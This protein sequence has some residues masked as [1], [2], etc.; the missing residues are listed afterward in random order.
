[1]CPRGSWTAWIFLRNVP[2]NWVGIS[3]PSSICC[4]TCDRVFGCCRCNQRATYSS[5]CS[6]TQPTALFMTSRQM[7]AESMQLFYGSNQFVIKGMAHKVLL[8]LS[9]IPVTHLRLV[10]RLCI[11]AKVASGKQYW[12]WRSVFVL[13]QEQLGTSACTITIVFSSIFTK[14]DGS[15]R[16]NDQLFIQRFYNILRE[17]RFEY[18][19]VLI[20]T[21]DRTYRKYLEWSE[22]RLAKGVY[23]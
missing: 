12:R 2:L 18:L 10:K 7:R 4:G 5:S 23:G 19:S 6:C 3:Q 15:L 20:R 1:M 9:D 22:D 21:P 14:S 16:M 13:L 8:R 11:D 17:F